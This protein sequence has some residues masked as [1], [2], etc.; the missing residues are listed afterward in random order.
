MASV[1]PPKLPLVLLKWF[2]HPGYHADIEGDLI[3]V[4]YRNVDESGKT[5]ADQILLKEVLLLFRPGIIKN[6]GQPDLMGDLGMYKNYLKV[7]WR[8]LLKQKLYAS[9]NIAG[10]AIGITCFIMIYF[11]VDHEQSYDLFYDNADQIYHVYE[12]TPDDEFRGSTS[13]AATPAQM[14]STLMH[15]YPEVEYATT[16]SEGFGLLTLD[17][18]TSFWE[19]GITADRNF[20]NV[21]AY[22]F[23]IYGSPSAAFNN[24]ESL[25]LTESLSMKI[26]GKRNSVGET[27][28]Y[29]NKPYQITGVI[30]DLPRNSTLQFS[31]MAN[32]EGNPRYLR[33]F[34]KDKWDGSDY[35]TFFSLYPSA[36]PS[37]LQAKMPELIDTYW[38]ADRPFDFEYLFRSL[39]EVHLSPQINNDFDLKGN[40][41]Q[42]NL[43]III[44]IL[45]LALACINYMNLSIARSINRAKEVGLRKTVG[46]EKKQLL[47]QFL[48]ESVFFSF[49]AFFIAL[50]LASA[51][52]P[53][54]GILLDRE[55]DFN[56][57][58]K[59]DLLLKIAGVIAVLGV[60]SGSYPAFVLSS[61]KPIQT[62]KGNL[63]GS[64]KKNSTQ[65]WMIT[66]QYAVSIVM[67][68]CT[69]IMYQ[70]FLFIGN[71][72]LGFEQDDIITIGTQDR[73]INDN[74]INIKN[75]WL[76]H[77]GVSAIAASH[78]LPHNVTS[79]TMLNDDDGGN[80]NDDFSISRLNIN[81]HEFL[82][83]Y[84]F[85]IIAGQ[86]LPVRQTEQQERFILINEAASGMMGLNPIE[87][88]GQII[89]DDGNRP[90]L[91]IMGVVKDFH[92]HPMHT[93]ISPVYIELKARDPFRYISVKVRTDN[94]QEL[95]AMM[96]GSLQQ[97]SER[98]FEFIFMEDRVNE[99]YKTDTQRATL[100]TSFSILAILI[101]S[102]GLFGLTALGVH[103]KRKEIGIRKVLGA[104][105]QNILTLVTG[106][107]LKMI[108]IGFLIAAPV[109]WF[110]MNNWLQNYAYRIEIDWWIFVAAGLISAGIAL[111]TISSQSIKAALIDPIHCIKDE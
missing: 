26:F 80:P 70:Q 95:I 17:E 67:V 84:G 62:L 106:S 39:P 57:L 108:V 100:F 75:E 14:A 45:I 6:L 60:L 98:P 97:Y 63:K 51:L 42:I 40:R 48:M 85:E 33:E 8:N 21:F 53:E 18:N 50:F 16:F 99:L 30:K 79:A 103:Q 19:E 22:D 29:N 43:F 74:F 13:W 83:I 102:L 28:D 81:N 107:F 64:V 58:G 23:F 27:L 89:T 78:S 59:P 69:L 66:A 4:Y 12:N 94:S 101:A 5:K 11:F 87:A 56:I 86:S 52:L 25:I 2:C 49:L 93:K 96:K 46:A 104:S 111:L 15:N 20:F 105:L 9:I 71:S 31:F 82:E 38:T 1:T 77:P 88:V 24:P 92:L 55:L 109:A 7:A 32:L 76:Q 90:Y 54:F 10:L 35:Y 91:T 47:T 41:Q 3:E 37:T 34:K 73:S 36:S 68:I 110:L 72:E 65:K 61:I 44:A